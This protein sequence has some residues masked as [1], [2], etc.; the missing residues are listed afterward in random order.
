MLKQLSKQQRST[1]TWGVAIG[2]IIVVFFALAS[3]SGG[4]MPTDG[5]GIVIRDTD[6]TKGGD[7]TAPVTL[8]EYAD[9]QCPACANAAPMIDQL[10]REFGD[11]LRIVFKHYPLTTIHRNAESS[12]RAA[13]AAAVSGKFWEMHD[14]LFERQ[15]EW[16]NLAD[17]TPKYEEY[18]EELGILLD[19]FRY[20]YAERAETAENVEQNRREALSL[21]LRGT[22]SIFI[23]GERIEQ[24]SMSNLRQAILAGLP[25]GYEIG[26]PE[27][28][29]P[30]K[31]AE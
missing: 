12:S 10:N 31:S 5:S 1:L 17:P 15:H 13:E 14:L 18:A 25:E 9:F 27:L 23:N 29:V 22:P 20:D 16:A 4:D 19:Q 2:I 11:D 30:T 6:H 28:T 3:M 8:V 21:G 7:V 26:Q 24:L